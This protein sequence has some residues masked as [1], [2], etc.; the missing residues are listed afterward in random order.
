M[1]K[2]FPVIPCDCHAPAQYNIYNKFGS[3]DHGLGR[4]KAFRGQIISVYPSPWEL[5]DL[6]NNLWWTS[7]LLGEGRTATTRSGEQEPILETQR[8]FKTKEPE[9]NSEKEFRN[10]YANKP[11]YDEI[12]KAIEGIFS[13]DPETFDSRLADAAHDLLPWTVHDEV[14]AQTQELPTAESGG[15]V[16]E[17]VRNFETPS[18]SRQP[19]S[20]PRAPERPERQVSPEIEPESPIQATVRKIFDTFEKA[21]STEPSTE[22]ERMEQELDRETKIFVISIL[23]S[24]KADQDKFINDWN[25]GENR[26]ADR[27]IYD[28]FRDISGN[29]RNRR[30]ENF[31]RGMAVLFRDL[32]N[33]K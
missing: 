4:F 27:Y 31:K 12:N 28:S 11:T 6:E 22:R 21:R 13:P 15:R 19:V 33:P 1:T 26:A 10:A 18:T 5:N 16:R 25:W 9:I 20:T 3:L 2:F 7:P 30:A 14:D 29:P 32:R 17:I 23:S 24:P 8:Q